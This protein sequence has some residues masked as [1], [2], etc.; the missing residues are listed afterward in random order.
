MEIINTTNEIAKMKSRD[1]VKLKCL[2]CSSEFILPKHRVLDYK[3]RKGSQGSFCSNRCKGIYKNKKQPISCDMCGMITIKSQRD[4]KN[5]KNHFC[6]SSC[7][8]KYWNSIKWPIQNR[9]TTVPR[10]PVTKTKLI[11]STCFKEFLRYPSSLKST[12]DGCRFCSRTCQAIYANR[13]WNRKPRFGINKSRC[14]T[15]L[16]NIILKAFPTIN[17]LENDRT[18]LPGS[19]EFDL[20][21]PDKKVGIELNGPCHYIPLF[22][23][24][25]LKTTQNND[26]KKMKYCQ[27]NNIKLFVIN[28]MGVKNQQQMLQESFDKQIKQHLL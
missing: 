13:T 25:A 18:T 11:C 16:K 22:G 14:E 3:K 27:D 23:N 7:S 9:H 6:S 20:Y 4:L 5:S 24:N 10:I 28:V 19:L 15:I 12:T 26:L 1:S 2:Q 8:A 17:I 21:I